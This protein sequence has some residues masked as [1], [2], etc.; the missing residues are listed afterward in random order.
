MKPLGYTGG[1]PRIDRL[2]S[3]DQVKEISV[4]DIRFAKR[5][6]VKDRLSKAFTDDDGRCV[7]GN[8]DAYRVAEEL[9]YEDV[10]YLLTLTIDT[11]YAEAGE[12]LLLSEAWPIIDSYQFDHENPVVV[13]D[14]NNPTETVPEEFW[15]VEFGHTYWSNP[16]LN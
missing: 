11:E 9:E 5:E 12:G 16:H 2:G 14:V 4:M 15:E 6:P 3:E 7:V 8:W 13:I 10:D 1:N